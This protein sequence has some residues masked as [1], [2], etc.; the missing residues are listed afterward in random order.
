MAW[1]VEGGAGD[2]RAGADLIARDTARGIG[3]F[4]LVVPNQLVNSLPVFRRKAVS[5]RMVA[6]RNVTVP[7]KRRRCG[8]HNESGDERDLH[9][10]VHSAIT[11]SRDHRFLGR[12]SRLAQTVHA[13][14]RA[15]ASD[16]AWYVRRAGGART[17]PGT[18][19]CVARFVKS[20]AGVDNVRKD[21]I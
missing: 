9:L 16:T 11:C 10:R 6:S 13:F 5:G 20:R 1:R 3:W 19:S 7:C 17:A 14:A 8:R 2:A 18:V 12:A 21:R 15:V 4:V